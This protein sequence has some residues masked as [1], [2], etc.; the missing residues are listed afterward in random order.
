MSVGA[1]KND[2]WQWTA[3]ST[4]RERCKSIFNQDPL[5]DVKFVVRDSKGGSESK[6]IP[7]QKFVLAISSPVFNAMFYGELA[8]T[9]DSVEIS[10]CEYESLLELFRFIYSEKANFTPNTVMQLMYLANKY[11]CIVA[12]KILLKQTKY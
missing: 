11:I 5:S 6:N 3:R 10:D 12:P 9:K 2:F 7:A 1:V 4:I 8:E